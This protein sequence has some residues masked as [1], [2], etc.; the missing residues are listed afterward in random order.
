MAKSNQQAVIELI[1][2]RAK[3]VLDV[4]CGTGELSKKL[5]TAS[6][7][8]EGLSPDI[9]H[10]ESYGEKIGAPFHQ[11]VFEDFQPTRRYDAIIMSES[12]Q[13]RANILRWTNYS[14]N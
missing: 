13:Y 10:K 2:D 12:C 9:N 5:K 3:T 6:Y 7:D 14:T 1:S 11:C 4:G 8:V